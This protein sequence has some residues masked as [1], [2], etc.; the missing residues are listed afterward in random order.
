MLKIELLPGQFAVARTNKRILVIAAVLV[1][2]A[3]AGAFLWSTSVKGQIREVNDELAGVTEKANEVRELRGQVE[4]KRVQSLPLK[5][6]LEFI[7]QADRSGTHFWDRFHEINSYIWSQAQVLN[8]SIVPPNSV[9]FSVILH[10]TDEVGRFLINLMRCGA[11]SNISISPMP[12][13]R[14]IQAQSVPGGAAVMS[15]RAGIG[16]PGAMGMQSGMGGISDLMGPPGMGGPPGMFGGGR[17]ATAGAEQLEPGSPDEEIVVQVTANLTDSITVPG[18]AGAAPADRPG[19]PRM[20]GAVGPM[21]GG[22]G[23]GGAGPI[24]VSGP[25]MGPG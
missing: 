21:G 19:M 25:E 3:A 5:R 8:F 23:G 16:G 18:P 22:G 10:G 24:T 11:L 14:S 13:G 4:S 20:G 9:Q 1:I 15:T 2:A 17:A 7:A 6:K 12:G